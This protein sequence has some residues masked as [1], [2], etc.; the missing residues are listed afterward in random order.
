MVPNSK[1]TSSLKI[2]SK[3]NESKDEN[4]INYDWVKWVNV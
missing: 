4:A 1:N 3:D 2:N